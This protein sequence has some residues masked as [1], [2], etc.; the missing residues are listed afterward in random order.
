MSSFF[1]DDR[2]EAMA[3]LIVA[4]TGALLAGAL[5][6]EHAFALDPCPLCL[7]QRIWFAFA[8]LIGLAA[9][10]HSTRWG[11]YPLLTIL[12]ALVGGGFSVRQLYLQSLPPEAVPACG[13]DMTYMLENFPLADLL[14]AMTRGTGDCA[15]VAWQFG[16]TIPGWALLGFAGI[17]VLGVLWLRAGLRA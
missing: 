10:L 8:G 13:P 9:L 6:M 4:A 17:V 5:V 12:A 1:F 15:Q 14:A 7:M 11:I 16:L 3:A 2:T